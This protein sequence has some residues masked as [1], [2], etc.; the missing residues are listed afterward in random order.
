MGSESGNLSDVHHRNG[1]D[2]DDEGQR[3]PSWNYFNQPSGLSSSGGLISGTLS[4]TVTPTFMNN[5]PTVV[6]H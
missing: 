5:A 6:M 2:G 4:S 3:A 1:G